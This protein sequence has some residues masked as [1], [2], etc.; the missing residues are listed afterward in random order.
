L[1]SEECHITLLF[2]LTTNVLSLINIVEKYSQLPIVNWQLSRHLLAKII[3]NTNHPSRWLFVVISK[4]KKV[5]E[6]L[7][8]EEIRTFFNDKTNY[9]R[10]DK[11]SQAYISATFTRE[12]A[13]KYG[14]SLYHL[15]LMFQAYCQDPTF[16]PSLNLPK[17]WRELGSWF[18]IDKPK[19]II[20]RRINKFVFAGGI[21]ISF[22]GIFATMGKSILGLPTV[23]NEKYSKAWQV[24]NTAE[25]KAGMG[26]RNEALEYLGKKDTSWYI[27][28]CKRNNDCLV[29]INIERAW[30]GSINLAGANLRYSNF[31]GTYLRGAILRNTN[32]E[33][34]DLKSIYLKD[35]DLTGATFEGADLTGATFEGADL[36]GATFEGAKKISR[37]AF[38]GAKIC[39]TTMPD[40][41]K[42][43]PN[44]KN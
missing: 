17:R 27:P 16:T 24:I 26:G 28:Q 42:E 34:A 12:Q 7:K 33:Y 2:D 43:N 9:L 40:G 20:R 31:S 11:L 29:N 44:C 13:S 4:N 41:H 32:F 6:N 39:R 15:R 19:N 3:D 1:Q 37:R 22:I 18:F 8:V 25:N 5:A 36:T 35:A 21:A 38:V 14:V 10:E 30:L 23:E